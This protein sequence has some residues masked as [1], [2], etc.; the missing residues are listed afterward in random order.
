[1][2]RTHLSTRLAL[3]ALG[4]VFLFACDDGETTDPPEDRPLPELC[5]DPGWTPGECI[6][7]EG[8]MIPGE[9][10]A[11]VAE[12]D[13]ITWEADPPSSGAHRPQWARWGEY[14]ELGADHWLHN[15]EH[16]GITVLYHPCTDPAI[17]EEMRELLRSI[18]DDDRGPFR[19][20]LT[21]YPDLP[22]SLAVLAWEWRYSAECVREDEVREF[23]DRY[24]RQAPE[25]VA[26]DG[27][28]DEGWLGR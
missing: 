6:A 8:R 3:A 13:A 23:I 27:R 17:V 18:P 12:P 20:I 28:Y 26:G 7:G 10:N 16:G 9:G 24:Y 19:W 21:S 22:S 15:M 25:D 5:E 11:H 14:A 1:M 2:T 4:V